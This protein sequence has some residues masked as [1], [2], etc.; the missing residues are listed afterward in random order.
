MPFAVYFSLGMGYDLT[1]A[2]EKITSPV[3][4]LGGELDPVA[5][6]E[7]LATYREHL[8]DARVQ[9]IPGAGHHPHYDQPQRYAEAVLAFLRAAQRRA[10]N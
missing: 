2:L 4:L 7:G 6:P 1:A 5:T 10:G 3:L 8:G 9:T